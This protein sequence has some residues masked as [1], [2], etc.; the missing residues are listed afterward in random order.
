MAATVAMAESI[1]MMQTR[2]QQIIHQVAEEFTRLDDQERIWIR[3]RL[4]RIALLQTELQ[5]LADVVDISTVCRDCQGSCCDCGKNHFGLVN[6]LF[7][8]L[9][10]EPL[11]VADFQ[12]GCP[13]LSATGCRLDAGRRPFN[14]VTFIC[15]EIEDRLIA[16]DCAYF[17]QLEKQLR[18]VYLE[19]EQRYAGAG[20]Y[21]LILRSERLGGRGFFAPGLSDSKTIAKHAETVSE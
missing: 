7:F 17:Y 21:G 1:Q 9:A 8:L 2:W 14:C 5:S 16:K 18:G 11:P 12:Q 6:L 4:A 3:S 10:D 19:F 15:D 13:F 20:A